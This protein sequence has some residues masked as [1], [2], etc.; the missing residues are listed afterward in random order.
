MTTMTTRALADTCASADARP[1][2]GNL[3]EI[4]AGVLCLINA[5]R[6][7]AGEA[8]LREDTQL[9]VAAQG[10]SED[11][12]SRDYFEHV[13]PGGDTPLQRMLASGYAGGAGTGLEVGENIAWGTLYLATPRAA[14]AA[15]MTSPEH[16]ANILDARFRDTGIGVCAHPPYALAHG[17]PGALYTQD[18]GVVFAGGAARHRAHRSP[19]HA[20]QAPADNLPRHATKRRRKRNGSTRR[21]VRHRHRFRARHRARHR[22]AA[23]RAGRARA[24]QRSRRRRR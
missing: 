1:D 5:E 22:R 23:R 12:A 10:H 20:G 3:Q 4:A 2:R 7:R 21:K 8:P 11:M 14:V 18:F 9:Q 6:Q 13:S 19:A 24:H 16:R 17:Q 15:W